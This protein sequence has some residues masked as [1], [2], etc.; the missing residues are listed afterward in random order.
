MSTPRRSPRLA[1]KAAVTD[2]PAAVRRSARLAAAEEVHH[3]AGAGPTLRGVKAPP[4]GPAGAGAGAGGGSV[5]LPTAVRIF[6]AAPTKMSKSKEVLTA[7]RKAP[8][9]KKALRAVVEEARAL[10]PQLKAARTNEEFLACGVVAEL[11]YAQALE[12]G[13]DGDL[14]TTY[15]LGDVGYNC[16]V[17]TEQDPVVCKE[18]AVDPYEAE[19]AC[20]GDYTLIEV[21]E[22]GDA[23]GLYRRLYCR[24]QAID[25]LEAFLAHMG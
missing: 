8:K 18:G 15:T 6:A 11:L 21:D 5:S 20:K 24:R 1:A 4:S 23:G 3:G 9:T 25:A 14:R 19:D 22:E 2:A 17:V 10:L 12:S 13:L 7:Y 16:Q